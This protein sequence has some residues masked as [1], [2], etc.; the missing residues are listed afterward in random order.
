MRQEFDLTTQ[1]TGNGAAIEP[2]RT[3]TL[4]NSGAH[5]ECAGVW[6]DT[7]E[8]I[9]WST[10]QSSVIA[11]PAIQATAYMSPYRDNGSLVVGV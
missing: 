4:V 11:S 9:T 5:K 10:N 7:S 6:A 3:Q 8:L 2:S 1:F